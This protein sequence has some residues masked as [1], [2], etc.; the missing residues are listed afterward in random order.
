MALQ[1]PGWPPPPQPPPIGAPPPPPQRRARPLLVAALVVGIVAVAAAVG[2]SVGLVTRGSQPAS[3]TPPTASGAPSP[4]P[5]S[6]AQALYRQTIA[7]MRDSAG[8]H[9]VAVSSGLATQRIEGDAGHD[10]GR[11]VITFD[12]MY[13]SE[14]FTLLLVQGTVYFQGNTPAI[15]DQ[16]GVPAAR[17]PSLQGKWVSVS[18][19]DGP[20]SVLQ[21]GI[22][23]ADQAQETAL[24]AA[25]ET[26]VTLLDGT[27]VIRISG[28]VPPQNGAPPGTGHLD[29]AVDSH[30]PKTYESRIL[31][32][33][34]T[35]TA[36]TTFSAWGTAPSVSAPT[37]AVAWSTLGASAPPGGYGSGG[38]NG[39]ASPSPSG[40][41]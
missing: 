25:A 40:I 15:E 39:A 16:L 14:Q 27:R 2:V 41:V 3:S 31:G 35:L 6:A 37:G 18:R 5:S 33:G 19:G 21:P 13:G 29:V 20:Y 7:A 32:G 4:V 38:G 36:S 24:V 17:A 22:T 26:Q 28:P 11:Q 10:D 9:Y 34:L 12:S 1:E 23:V 30:V 8:F